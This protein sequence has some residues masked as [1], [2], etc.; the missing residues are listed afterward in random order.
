M[1]LLEAAL[2]E[3]RGALDGGCDARVIQILKGYGKAFRG[4]PCG[5]VAA[6]HTSTDNMHVLDTVSL[7]TCAQCLEPVLQFEDTHQI[8]RGRMFEQAGHR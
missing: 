1:R 6:H 3:L 8:G 2:V 7:P 5:Y 4:T